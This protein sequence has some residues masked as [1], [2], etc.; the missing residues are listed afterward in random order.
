MVGERIEINGCRRSDK[1]Q[2]RELMERFI[3]QISL[4]DFMFGASLYIRHT[5]TS[6]RYIVCV[7][8]CMFFCACM[9]VYICKY[10]CLHVCTCMRAYLVIALRCTVPRDRFSSWKEK[11]GAALSVSIRR[12]SDP[13]SSA[14]GS[15]RRCGWLDGEGGEEGESRREG[16]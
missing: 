10:V 2:V 6:T 3:A 16:G 11:R 4:N 5:I 1:E 15:V 12:R 7:E 9:C 13:I 14:I 8:V